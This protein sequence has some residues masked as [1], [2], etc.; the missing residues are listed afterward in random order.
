MVDH[1]VTINVHRGHLCNN[2]PNFIEQRYAIL[3]LHY[4]NQMV[5]IRSTDLS[6]NRKTLKVK[7]DSFSKD[8][9]V[10]LIATKFV[11]PKASSFF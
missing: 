5:K 10:H 1:T 3:E 4:S 7:L 8:T 6:K 9:R 2:L 11:M